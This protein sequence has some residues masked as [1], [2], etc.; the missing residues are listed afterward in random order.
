[1]RKRE[2]R[3]KCQLQSLEILPWLPRAPG[4]QSKTIALWTFFLFLNYLSPV[5]F[6]WPDVF[7]INQA[8]FMNAMPQGRGRQPFRS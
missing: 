6:P 3:V 1:M 7:L 5:I 8:K 2:S 4:T